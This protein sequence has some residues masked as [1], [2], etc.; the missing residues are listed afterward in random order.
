MITD[1]SPLMSVYEGWD[2]HQRSLIRTIAP[3]SPQQLAYRPAPHLRSVGEIASHLSLGRVGWFQRMQ[4]P[5]SKEVVH[6]VNGWEEEHRIVENAAELVRRLEVTWQMIE[7]T[8]NSWTISDLAQTYQHTYWGKTYA[9]SRQWT[10]WRIMSHDLHHGGEL[11][12]LLGIQ[13][14]NAP[15]LG[16]LGGHITEPPLAEPS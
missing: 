8:L 3:L 12:I 2:G 15:E 4:A 16:D 11:V 10:I 1:T 9:I 6:Q 14:I 7:T 5:G 13:G